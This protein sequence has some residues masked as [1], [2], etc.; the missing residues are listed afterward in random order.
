MNVISFNS[1]LIKWK[2]VNQ[3]FAVTKG[4]SQVID[5]YV[6]F[7]DQI[8]L[9]SSGKDSSLIQSLLKETLFS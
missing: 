4:L 5:S 7:Y 1:Y 2:F 6:K 3:L 8:L 9:P